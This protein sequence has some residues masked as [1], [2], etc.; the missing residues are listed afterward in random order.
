MRSML[1]GKRKDHRP[2]DAPFLHD[3][4]CRI[5]RADPGFGDPPWSR[6]EG[7][8]WNRVCVCNEETWYE[9]APRRLQLD[10]LD[11]ATTRHFG[12]C[13]YRDVT[14]P[15]LLKVLLKVAQGTGGDYWWVTCGGCDASWAVP[16]YGAESAG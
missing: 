7:G 6:L 14:D 12:E 13:E 9:P 15:A 1:P 2:P 8:R 10:P 5:V 4:G 3:D 11:P 16:Y